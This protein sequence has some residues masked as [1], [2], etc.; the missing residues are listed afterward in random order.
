MPLL[1]FHP[2]S[3]WQIFVPTLLILL[4]VVVVPA[5]VIYF[6]L[7]ALLKRRRDKKKLADT[8]ITEDFTHP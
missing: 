1:H 5:V 7:Y 2:D 3:L 8:D 6:I 4:F